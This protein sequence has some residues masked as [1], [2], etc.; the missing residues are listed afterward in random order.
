MLPFDWLKYFLRFDWLKY[1]LHFDW[2]KRI[3]RF[4]FFFLHF[5]NGIVAGGTV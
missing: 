5:L 3:G 4:F 2:L 1:F